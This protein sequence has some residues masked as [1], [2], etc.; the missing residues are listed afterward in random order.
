MKILMVSMNSIHFRRWTSQLEDAGHE[1]FWFDAKGAE[2]TSKELSWVHQKT[3]WRLRIKKGRYILKK[4]PF[5]NKLNTRSIT[6]AF[7]DYLLMVQPD[8]VQSFVLYMSC[9]P[10]LEVMKRHTHI[11][12]VYSAWGN[13]L[14]YYQ[15]V[16]SYKKEIDLVLPHLHYMFADCQRDIDLA[17]KLGF[18]GEVLGVFPGGGGYHLDLID[19]PIKTI[20]E[21]DGILVKGYQGEKHRGLNVLKAI[22]HLD[23]NSP[24]TFFSTDQSILDYYEKSP[25]LKRKNITFF[26]S[27]NGLTH[28]ELC[29]SMN[30]SLLYIG[31]N[32]SDGMP[33]TLLEAICFGAFPIQSNP[34]GASAEII[35]DG[36]NGLLIGNCEDVEE[37]RMK[38]KEALESSGL[39]HKAFEYN[40]T[41]RDDLSFDHIKGRV[42]LAYQKIN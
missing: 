39:L 42:Q 26:T 31:N 7:E 29:K 21:R 15:H 34:G 36:V 40:M 6:K 13:D 9:A 4:I 41:L 32:L 11:K 10:I 30:N 5:L 8:I 23:I 38:I 16:P 2:G 28:K 25:L 19:E 14:F 33:N 20:S 12:W 37:I 17:K 18:E 3:N 35:N 22:E 27:S 24:I 1:V